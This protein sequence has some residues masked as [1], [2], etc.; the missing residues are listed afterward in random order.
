MTIFRR[1]ANAAAGDAI[2]F[3]HDGEVHL[4]YLSS[5]AGTLDYPERVRTTWQHA[6]SRDLLRWEELPPAVEPGEVDAYDGGGIWTGSVV[7]HDGTF[8]LFYTGHHVAAANPQTICLA[9]STDLV[10]FQKHPA[11]PLVLPVEGCEPV[12]W[13]DPYVFFNEDE[14]VWWMLIAARRSDGPHWSRGCIMLATSP[15]LL[16]WTV[17]PEPL[18]APGTTYC[19]ECPELWRDDA[20]RWHLVYS[21]FSEE[22]GTVSRVAESPRG[23]FREP[24]R[25]ELGGRRWYASKSARNPTGDGR[26]FFGWIHDRVTDSR[27]PRWLWGGD[28]ATPRIVTASREGSLDVRP[29]TVEVGPALFATGRLEGIGGS[30]AAVVASLLPAR[31]RLRLRFGASAGTSAVGVSLL[32]DGRGA[33]WRVDIMLATGEV[34]LRREPTPLDDFWADLTGRAAEYR[35]VDGEFVARGRLRA[36]T[37]GSHLELLLDGDL[38]EAYLGGEVALTHRLDAGASYAATV[39]VVDGVADYTA[40]IAGLDTPDPLYAVR[41]IQST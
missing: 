7:E 41:G 19:P 33:G 25:P 26:V 6:R 3:E 36:P 20:D 21:R 2:P 29:V 16:A 9:T 24:S 31:S 4:F 32:T 13:R 39:F 10:T 11:N 12:D 28:F 34:R 37:S 5:P 1:P 40:E 18:Y 35:E 15:D 30:A 23:P 27:G 8:Y 17:E 22:A 38:F 14:R